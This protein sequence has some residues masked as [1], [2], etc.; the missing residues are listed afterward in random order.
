MGR[1]AVEFLDQGLHRALFDAMP[2][3]VFLV[4][5]D[6]SILEYNT[7]ASGLLKSP[8]PEE[9]GRRGGE[10]LGC[11]HAKETPLGCGHSESCVDCVVRNSVAA[12]SKSQTTSRKPAQLDLVRRGKQT[13]VDVRVSCQPLT[14]GKQ[15][16]YLLVLEGLEDPA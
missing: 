2:V 15:S 3:P 4:D 6:V 10:V 8:K 9:L 13:R 1:L 7:A 5:K 16:Y 12:A 11:I 14:Y